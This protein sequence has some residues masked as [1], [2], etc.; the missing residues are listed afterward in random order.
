MWWRG[1]S[2]Q[3]ALQAPMPVYAVDRSATRRVSGLS[4][5]GLRGVAQPVAVEPVPDGVPVDPE[6]AGDLGE[7]PRL[8]GHAVNQIGLQAGEAEL[9]GALGEVPAGCWSWRWRAGRTAEPPPHHGARR[10]TR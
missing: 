8:L 7:R 1:C 5:C 9:G 2:P 6:L 10:R 4:A 3:C